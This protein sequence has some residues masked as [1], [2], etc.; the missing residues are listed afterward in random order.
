MYLMT[1]L[2]TVT[3]WLRLPVTPMLKVEVTS[4]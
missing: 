4:E 1:E 3:L 2:V